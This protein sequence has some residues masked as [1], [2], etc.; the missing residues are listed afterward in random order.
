MKSLERQRQIAKDRADYAAVVLAGA[1]I[2]KRSQS[3]NDPYWG[4]LITRTTWFVEHLPRKYYLR[5]PFNTRREAV[6]SAQRDLE[7]E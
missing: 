1:V 6:K 5:G 2:R 4:R 3:G 7:A